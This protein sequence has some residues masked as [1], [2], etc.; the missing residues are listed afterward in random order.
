MVKLVT[1]FT[2]DLG[3]LI[4]NKTKQCFSLFNQVRDI[5]VKVYMCVNKIKLKTDYKNNHLSI[6]RS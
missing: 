4:I 1:L 3:I 2:L 6:I 5:K